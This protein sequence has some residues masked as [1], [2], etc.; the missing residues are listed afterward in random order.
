MLYCYNNWDYF[1]E[2]HE[3]GTKKIIW[4]WKPEYPVSMDVK[5]TNCC[6][7]CCPR[8]HEKSSLYWKH[9]DLFKYIP[10]FFQ[11]P[12]GTELAIWGWN[13]LAHPNLVLF[14]DRLKRAWIIANL[15]INSAHLGDPWVKKLINS[16]LIYWLGVSYNYWQKEDIEKMD[17][18][19]MVV[20]MIAGIHSFDKIL[21]MLK[22][23]KKVLILW[24]KKWGK[25]EQYYSS[26]IEKNIK[27]LYIKLGELFWKWLVSFDNLAIKQLNPKRFF[28]ADKWNK[29]YMWDDWFFTMY[30]DLVKNEYAKNS[31]AEKRFE[32]K[33]DM[34][35]I[36][37][38]VFNF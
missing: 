32:I 28:K 36:F 13:P 3:D 1:I 37:K 9:W 31:I 23:W 33:G 24:Y 35:T 4:E 18:W 15:T 26:H 25:W 10:L 6:D 30:M 2:I 20:H 11:L 14:L 19:N 29:R 16:N 8:C 38:K 22:K 12:K 21:D 17:Y 5:I 7:L 27:E 34:K